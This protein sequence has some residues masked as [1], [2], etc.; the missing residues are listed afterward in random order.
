MECEGLKERF[1]V[2]LDGILPAEE[3]TLLEEHLKSCEKCRESL[4]DLRKTVG[5]VRDLEDIEPPLWLTGKVMA[6]IRAEAELKKGII[7]RLFYPLSL[8]LPIQA[9]ATVL[10]VAT[11]LYVFRIM[12]PEVKITERIP[13]EIPQNILPEQKYSTTDTEKG[14]TVLSPRP[15]PHQAPEMKD[16]EAVGASAAPEP[17]EKAVP[18][19]RKKTP[20]AAKQE[21][22][23]TLKESIKKECDKPQDFFR[24]S[25]AKVSDEKI[26]E[27]KVVEVLVKD[28]AAATKEIE[29]VL[30][31]LNGKIVNTEY[32]ENRNVLFAEIPS[33]KMNEFLDQLMPIGEVQEKPEAS[34]LALTIRITIVRH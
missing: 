6:K 19:H 28:I 14:K 12:E 8:K 23:V 1:S 29:A 26:P 33:R 32:S 4:A 2:Y 21:Q 11:A 15:G 20:A 3:R 10:I 30:L 9:V 22:A 17:K 5:H 27:E 7:E 31:K 24:S 16:S 13:E 34:E 18:N 25:G